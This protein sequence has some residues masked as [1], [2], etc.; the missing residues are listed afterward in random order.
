MLRHGI[1][2]SK[3]GGDVAEKWQKASNENEPAPI[4]HKQPLTD[5]NPFFCESNASAISHQ[6]LMPEPPADPKAD[7]LAQDCCNDAGSDQGPDIDV[8]CS[9]SEKRSRDQSRLGRQRKPNAFERD[10]CRDHPD[11]IV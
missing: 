3:H 9:G 8:V 11:A 6:Y 4:S 5:S 2:T 1:R 10:E 7:H